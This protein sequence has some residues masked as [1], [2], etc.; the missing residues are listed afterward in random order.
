[1]ITYADEKLFPFW[2]PPCRAIKSN[3]DFI[4][5]EGIHAGAFVSTIS[6]L[7]CQ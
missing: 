6:L 7:R 3:I 4:M 2:R 5:H 1:M